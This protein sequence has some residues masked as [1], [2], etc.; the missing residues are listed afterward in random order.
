MEAK[1]PYCSASFDVPETVTTATCPYCGLTFK[2]GIGAEE[3]APEVDHFYFPLS[4]TDPIGALTAFLMRQVGVPRDLSK[5]SVFVKRE[6]NYIPVHFFRIEG[7]A[8]I[9]SRGGKMAVVEEL[10]NLGSWPPR[11]SPGFLKATGSR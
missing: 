1:C 10:D 7:K 5:G 2:V 11:P 3:K 6:L 8:S 4:Q 9:E